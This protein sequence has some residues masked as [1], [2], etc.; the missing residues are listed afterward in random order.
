MDIV[1]RL[2]G[3]IVQA[4][5]ERSHPY[6]ADTAKKAVEEINRLRKIIEGIGVLVGRL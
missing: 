2:E 3:L 5:R 1:Q 4:T 6:V